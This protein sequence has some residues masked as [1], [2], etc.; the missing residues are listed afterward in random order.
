[1]IGTIPLTQYVPAFFL[2]F[3]FWN[4]IRAGLW[5]CCTH[6]RTGP[7]IDEHRQPNFL[8][9]KPKDKR[10]QAYFHDFF[11][12]VF[13][14]CFKNARHMY[15]WVTVRC[16]EPW[17]S[18]GHDRS[19]ARRCSHFGCFFYVI[20]H[21]KNLLLG[22]SSYDCARRPPWRFMR[23]VCSSELFFLI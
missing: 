22:W 16:C 9:L 7:C 20:Y 23:I 19:R 6:V 3:F 13:G 21:H 10:K 4:N 17:R 8:S 11:L 2:F 5:C 1:M 18:D 14:S 15:G 12:Y